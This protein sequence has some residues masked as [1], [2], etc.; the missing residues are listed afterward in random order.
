MTRKCIAAVKIRGTIQAPREVRETLRLLNLKR[1]NY[2]VLIDNR[3]SYLGML[4][5]A[6]N[7][8]TWGEVSR[9]IIALML[10]KRGR[11]AGNK[12]ISEDYLKRIGYNSIEEL[13]D[14]IFNCK[15]EYSRLPEIQ[16]YFRLHPPAKGFKGKIKKGYLM[17]GELGYRGEDIN[18][19]IR[20]MI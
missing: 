16:P 9:E 17:G 6:Q 2:A 1:T 11:I 14:A 15:V 18:N 12:A 4:R 3:P 8:I 10:E 19:L 13:A 20:R 7:F 5:T